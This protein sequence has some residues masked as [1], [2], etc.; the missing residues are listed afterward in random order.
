M[1]YYK[2]ALVLGI[3]LLGFAV[4]S[5]EI[6]YYFFLQ[7]SLKNKENAVIAIIGERYPLELGHEGDENRQIFKELYRKMWYNLTSTL[8]EL[9][10]WEFHFF[11]EDEYQF[12]EMKY[13]QVLVLLE[14]MGFYSETDEQQ[15]FTLSSGI[16]TSVRELLTPILSANLTVISSTSMLKNDWR[17][18]I[19]TI[20]EQTVYTSSLSEGLEFLYISISA[21]Q[22]ETLVYLDIVSYGSCFLNKLLGGYGYAEVNETLWNYIL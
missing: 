15:Y 16:Q 5:P 19:E 8:A 3:I 9:W 12:E 14:G 11:Y 21:F 18:E 20:G 6:Y 22:N 10:G 1:N 2:S 4:Y 13:N 17:T 7:D